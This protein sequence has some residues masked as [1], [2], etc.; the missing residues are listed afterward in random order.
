MSG[1]ERKRE[2]RIKNFFY[3]LIFFSIFLLD[4]SIKRIVSFFF[5]P[6]EGFPII[7]KIFHITLVFNKGIAFGLFPNIPLPFLILGIII[8]I[9]FIFSSSES[10]VK[11]KLSLSLIGAGTL[12]NLLDRLRFG[13]VIDYL[14]FRIWPVF[15]LGDTAITIGMGLFLWGFFRNKN[16]KN[17]I[18]K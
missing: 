17:Q 9:W 13:Y 2:I 7:K 16:I 11:E 4:Q 12:S 1:Q 14:D 3:F 15:N 6:G 18:S 8:F 10:L 5:L